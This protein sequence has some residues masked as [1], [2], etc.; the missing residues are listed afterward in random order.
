MSKGLEGM[1][2]LTV[3]FMKVNS[4]ITKCMGTEDLYKLMGTVMKASFKEIKNMERASLFL[5]NLGKF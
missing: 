5:E 2:L 3:R 1:L 4:K